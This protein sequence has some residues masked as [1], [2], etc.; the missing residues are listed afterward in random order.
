MTFFLRQRALAAPSAVLLICR[1]RRLDALT[2]DRITGLLAW[3]LLAGGLQPGDVVV[4]G[5][6]DPLAHVVASLAC[7]RAGLAQISLS[8]DMPELQARLTLD[9]AGAVAALRE[10]EVSPPSWNLPDIA[11][12][13]D[14][15]LNDRSNHPD[16]P[17]MPAPRPAP[18]SCRARV[19]RGVRGSLSTPTVVWQACCPGRSGSGRCKPASA[20]SCCPTLASS[21]PSGT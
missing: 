13:L 21:L 15:L 19:P 3:R 5:L 16:I 2:L 11:L 8:P 20:I 12:S 1:S 6:S 17:C 7:L 10:A 18:C 9:S 14:E 4:L